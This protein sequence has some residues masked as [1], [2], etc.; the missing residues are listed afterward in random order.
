MLFAF[1]GWISL[2]AQAPLEIFAEPPNNFVFTGQIVLYD[3]FIHR[4]SAA[5]DFILRT[6]DPKSPYVRINYR[7]M[8]GFDA[9]AATIDEILDRK[10][11]SGDGSLWSFQIFRPAKN[12][13]ESFGCNS[14]VWQLEERKDGTIGQSHLS[15]FISVPG[16]AA[17]DIP[18]IETLPCYVLR[19]KSWT[20][21]TPAEPALKDKAPTANSGQSQITN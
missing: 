15:R 11:F 21:L 5:D 17:K 9:P 4:Y 14:T 19:Y 20:R 10:A 8:W 18:P 16:A 13:E 3:P 2:S 7:P 1:A 12:S 6:N